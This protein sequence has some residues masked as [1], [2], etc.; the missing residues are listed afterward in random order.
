MNLKIQSPRKAYAGHLLNSHTK[1]QL[2]G[3][4]WRGGR[5]G[6]SG[7]SGQK[8]EDPRLIFGYVIPF[9]IIYRLPQKGTIIAVLP[10]STPLPQIWV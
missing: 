8:G 9:W 5:S 1:F 4:I 6:I 7:F 10:L 3:S 2:P